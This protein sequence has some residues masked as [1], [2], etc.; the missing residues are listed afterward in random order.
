[1][2]VIEELDGHNRS[3]V[4]FYVD[5]F[6]V[7]E[8]PL[9]VVRSIWK[10]VKNKEMNGPLKRGLIKAILEIHDENL[11]VYLRVTRNFWEIENES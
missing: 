6:H 1:M 4:K 8:H 9:S 11:K 3:R 10:R 5:A 2:K 7:G